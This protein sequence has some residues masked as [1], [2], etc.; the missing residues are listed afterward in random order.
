MTR[1]TFGKGSQT[2]VKV[3]G[4]SLRV[5]VPF[6]SGFST[7]TAPPLYEATPDQRV[8]EQIASHAAYARRCCRFL[9]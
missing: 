4:I 9:K 1:L 7:W 3:F 2:A 5:A 8:I 6:S